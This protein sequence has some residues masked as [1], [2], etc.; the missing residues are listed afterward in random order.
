MYLVSF[1][2]VFNMF[3]PTLCCSLRATFEEIN[4]WPVLL[5]YTA[6]SQKFAVC[7]TRKYFNNFIT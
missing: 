3:L 1:V 2:K 5:A 7:Q 4:S 6:D